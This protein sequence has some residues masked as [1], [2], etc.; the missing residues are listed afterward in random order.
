MVQPLITLIMP[1]YN[2]ENWIERAIQSVISQTYT[3]WELIIVNDGSTDNTKKICESFA[4]KDRRIKLLNER[5]KGVCEAKNN[6][7]KFVNGDYF[8]IIDSDDRLLSYALEKFVSTAINTN[9]DIVISG[10]IYN[11]DGKKTSRNVVQDYTFN[12]NQ[13]FNSNEIV[14]LV[15]S[16]T[17]APNWNKLLNKKFLINKF[18]SS[19]S[20]NEDMIFSLN[21]IKNANKIS[22]LSDTLYEYI[23]QKNSLSRVFHA[24]FIDSLDKIFEIV[25]KDENPDLMKIEIQK[26]IL[27]QWFIFVKNLCLN[28]NYSIDDKIALL[29][30]AINSNSFRYYGKLKNVD[31]TGRRIGLVLLKC[32]LYKIYLKFLNKRK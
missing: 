27:D 20:I 7:L 23:I 13:S 26:W 4:K 5:N 30:K 6:A 25:I 15:E 29:K 9:S 17:I 22:V 2:A 18:D 28:R 32:K 11:V 3:N 31:T 8:L 14:Q 10:Y 19:I 16:A 1:A 21:C 12:P 24:E